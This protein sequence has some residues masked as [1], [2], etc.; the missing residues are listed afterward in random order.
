MKI[1]VPNDSLRPAT[2]QAV[3]EEFVTRE[4]AVHGHTDTPLK[5]QIEMVRRQLRSGEAVIVFDQATE[6]CTIRPAEEIR[7]ARTEEED[8]GS[9]DGGIEPDEP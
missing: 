9:A 7:I 6:S 8:A 4:G 5:V 1:I 3:I 2:L